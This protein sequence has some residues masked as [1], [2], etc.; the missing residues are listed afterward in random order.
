MY[1]KLFCQVLD[2]RILDLQDKMSL[3]PRLQTSIRNITLQRNPTRSDKSRLYKP[4][5]SWVSSRV[6]LGVPDYPSGY[7]VI[8]QEKPD[9][10]QYPVRHPAKKIRF[11]PTH[12]E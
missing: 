11:G 5:K 10:P 8:R 3:L 9:T 7:P 1:L 4:E 2:N 12:S 6:G